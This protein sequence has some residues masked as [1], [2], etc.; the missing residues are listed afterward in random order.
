MYAH[1]LYLV[2]SNCRNWKQYSNWILLILWW[3]E[4]DKK[5]AAAELLKYIDTLGKAG[6]TALSLKDAAP[7]DINETVG[8]SPLHSCLSQFLHD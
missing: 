8:K 7:A 1:Y 6:Y 5:Q 3:Q 4:E 2:V